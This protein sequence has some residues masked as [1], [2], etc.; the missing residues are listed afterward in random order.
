VAL[1]DPGIQALV[2]R[3]LASGKRERKAELSAN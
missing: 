2:E 1:E 3:S